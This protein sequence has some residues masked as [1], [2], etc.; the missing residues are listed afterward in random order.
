MLTY[1]E[2]KRRREEEESAAG[3]RR[4]QMCSH[5][6]N[7]AMRRWQKQAMA[8]AWGCWYRSAICQYLYFC[9]CKAR[10]FVPVKQELLRYEQHVK[11]ERLRS[12]GARVVKR[13]TQRAIVAAWYS[14]YLL[15]LV[16][17]DEY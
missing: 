15:L 4:G 5:M 10:T 7:K 2:E 3:K 8:H 17:K 1:A 9:T 11:L 14:V 6:A 13:W 12:A 16:Q